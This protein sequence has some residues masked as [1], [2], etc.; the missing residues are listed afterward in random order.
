LKIGDLMG[1]VVVPFM[2]L[3]TDEDY[4]ALVDLGQKVIDFFAENALEHDFSDAY[5]DAFS[6]AVSGAAN[7]EDIEDTTGGG[8]GGGNGSGGGNG[9]DGNGDDGG[10][11]AGGGD[12]SETGPE[13]SLETTAASSRRAKKRRRKFRP[14]SVLRVLRRLRDANDTVAFRSSGNLRVMLRNDPDCPDNELGFDVSVVTTGE[15]D[16]VERAL[17]NEIDVMPEDDGIGNIVVEEYSFDPARDPETL[18]EIVDFLDALDAWRVC[19]CGDYIIKDAEQQCY[20]CDL[21][22]DP[23]TTS[24][25]ICPICHEDVNN[26]RWIF[27]TPCC[28]QVMHRAC[29]DAC[30]RPPLEPRCPMCRVQW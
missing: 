6:N 20:Y 12:A 8:G 22:T 7:T 15:P 4:E 18:T 19:P 5:D 1:T 29:R 30:A 17:S 28:R 10:A 13:T 23:E 11:T 16:A 26:P 27:R 9:D 24:D 21:M 2:P 3:K 25:D 14:D